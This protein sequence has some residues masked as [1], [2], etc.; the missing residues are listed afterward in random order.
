MKILVVEDE[1]DLNYLITKILKQENYNVDSCHDGDTAL[2][3]L[4]MNE[5]DLVI[6]DIMLPKKMAMRYYQKSKQMNI[7]LKFYF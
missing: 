1:K 4:E 6:L 2:L 5:Y 7:I 3:F